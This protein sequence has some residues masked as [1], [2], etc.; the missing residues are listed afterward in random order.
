MGDD[1][2]LMSLYF[3]ER[4]YFTYSSHQGL[5]AAHVIE[6]P[7][8][9]DNSVTAQLASDTVPLLHVSLHHLT[10]SF[11]VRK[12]LLTDLTL[13]V[14]R[15]VFCVIKFSVGFKDIFCQKILS[16][17]FAWEGCGRILLTHHLQFI[18]C[19]NSIQV[20]TEVTHCLSTF[21]TYLAQFAEGPFNISVLD[22]FVIYDRIFRMKVLV[23]QR[24]FELQHLWNYR[25]LLIVI[26]C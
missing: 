2:K 11:T 22:N 20:S 3:I 7:H 10:S 1:T 26:F 14:P 16:T 24:T 12:V 19:V 18:Y 15:F 5:L 17:S 23:T 25:L 4:I 6:N 9:V 21:K 8:K 13:N